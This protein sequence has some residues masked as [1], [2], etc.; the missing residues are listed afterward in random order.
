MNLKIKT[1]LFLIALGLALTLQA[2]AQFDDSGFK[3][4]LKVKKGAYIS[5]GSFTGGDRAHSDFR[6]QN[7]RIA[8]N[9]AGYDRV[10]VDFA[11]NDLGEKSRL[12]RPPY[13]MVDIDHLNKRVNITV[14]GKPKL[15]FSTQATLQSAKKTKV[16]AK[17]DFI[18]M[19]N[20]DRWTFTLE[21][22]SA[23]KAEVFDLSEPARLIIDLKN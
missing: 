6:V 19:V 17:V 9:P 2:R 5:D 21:G 11:G 15:D 18:P 14:Y 12:A 20:N 10:V 7:I 8:S 23:L 3:Q 13:Y 1:S 22:K 4:A 16:L